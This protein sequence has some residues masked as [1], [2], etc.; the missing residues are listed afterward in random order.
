MFCYPVVQYQVVQQ[1]MYPLTCVLCVVSRKSIE[2]LPPMIFRAVASKSRTEGE[3]DL[4]I[5]HVRT[6]SVI[7][8]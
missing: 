5:V 6:V 7:S 1:C 8:L 2:R 3:R 4:N